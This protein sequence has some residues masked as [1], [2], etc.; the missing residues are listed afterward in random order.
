MKKRIVKHHSP[1]TKA[2]AF[3]QRSEGKSLSDISRVLKVPENT[4]KGWF[5]KANKEASKTNNFKKFAEKKVM[6]KVMDKVLEQQVE[7]KKPERKEVHLD[8]THFEDANH[9]NYE[10]IIQLEDKMQRMLQDLSMI[11]KT[12]QYLIDRRI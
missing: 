5:L 1:T 3:T 12:T 6:E 8:F 9:P 11:H 4:L 7:Y 10:I 2:M